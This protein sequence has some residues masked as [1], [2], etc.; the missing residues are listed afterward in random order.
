MATQTLQQLFDSFLC[1]EISAELN[2]LPLPPASPGKA[3]EVSHGLLHPPK[4]LETA[5][6]ARRDFP[7]Q[8]SSWA[9]KAEDVWE[10]G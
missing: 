6:I 4:P 10:T 3:V 5:A 9:E 2:V 1:W 7:T 8:G